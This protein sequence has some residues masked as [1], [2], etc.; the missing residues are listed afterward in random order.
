MF[1]IGQ[2][3]LSG[4]R[5]GTVEFD[6]NSS[7]SGLIG[8]LDVWTEVMT[9]ESIDRLARGCPYTPGDVISLPE[10]QGSV[11][12]EANFTTVKEPCV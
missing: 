4:K 3:F 7:R 12:G 2:R 6:P 5:D 9:A 10:F 8:S 11:K 1:V